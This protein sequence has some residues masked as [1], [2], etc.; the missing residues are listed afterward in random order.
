M[1]NQREK[2]WIQ[3]Y[4]SFFNGYNKTLG[5][6]GDPQ[7]TEEDISRAIQAYLDGVPI[8]EIETNYMARSTLYKYLKAANI[9]YREITDYAIQSS[10]ENAKKATLAKQIRVCNI[11]LN[12]IYASKKDA[13]LDMIQRGYSNAKDWHN[14]RTTLDKALDKTQKTAFGFEWRYVNE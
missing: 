6:Q 5:G 14:I 11:T 8:M 12:I 13:L 3:F 10:I 4:D 7:Y 9:P 1:L 2:Y